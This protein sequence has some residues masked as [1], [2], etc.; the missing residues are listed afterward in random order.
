MYSCVRLKRAALPKRGASLACRPSAIGKAIAR[1]EERLAVRLFH[2]STRSIALTQEGALFL[3]R[4][5]ADL[6]RDR[7]RGAGIGANQ[8][9]TPAAP[10]G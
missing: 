10:C 9:R 1:L 5:P 2:R 3:E 8:A 6:R 7:N 4:L